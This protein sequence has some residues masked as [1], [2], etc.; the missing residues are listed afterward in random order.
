ME[1]GGEEQAAEQRSHVHATGALVGGVGLP[2]WA[3]VIRVIEF[4]RWGSLGRTDDGVRRRELAEVDARL[5]EVEFADRR[6]VTSEEVGR[7]VGLRSVV[8]GRD[9]TVAVGEHGDLVRP[10]SLA[11][12]DTGE[13]D[14]TG[15]H[16]GSTLSARQVV[17]VDIESRVEG[18]VA[19]NLLQLVVRGGND[20]R[21][22]QADVVDGSG[23]GFDDLYRRWGHRSGVLFDLGVVDLVRGPC[24]LDVAFD[25][26]AFADQFAWANLELLDDQRVDATH[27]HRGEH[28]QPEADE[29][30]NPLPA[31]RIQQEQQP[32]EQRDERQDV[33]RGKLCVDVGVLQT[34]ESARKIAA[35]DDE[36][37]AVEPVRDRL[38]E[39][40]DGHGDRDLDLRRRR[41]PVT[42]WLQ[43]QTT[44]E[45]VHD[46]TEREG[47]KGCGEGE[48]EEEPQERQFERVEGHIKTELRV[49]HSE[50]CGVAPLQEA[51]PLARS[52]QSAEKP[53]NNR[54][55]QQQASLERFDRLP[56]TLQAGLLRG[57]PGESRPRSV[58]DPRREQHNQ[59]HHDAESEKQ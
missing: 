5:L 39:Q 29:R 59:G 56:V 2:R 38:E 21:V 36:V 28:H 34:R 46:D 37:V 35:L 11:I 22:E 41:R 3:C 19:T 31:E 43:T 4:H 25:V 32:D 23:A 27:N 42:L 16:H 53:E 1:L 55:A 17:A 13:V 54:Q 51:S 9:E 20:R 7:P 30:N 44:E 14:L 18:V 40:E 49:S 33:Q 10:I 15:R 6:D 48:S 57:C 8:V 50:G 52:R 12:G 58:G 45:V 26:R 47:D 24:R